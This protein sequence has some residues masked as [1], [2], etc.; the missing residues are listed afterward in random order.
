MPPVLCHRGFQRAGVHKI[1]EI[2]ATRFF[3]DY[4]LNYADGFSNAQ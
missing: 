2:S 3:N 1:V 4:F